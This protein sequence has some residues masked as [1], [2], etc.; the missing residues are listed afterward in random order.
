MNPPFVLGLGEALWDSL[1]EGLR[2]GGA[3]LNLAWHARQLGA[4]AAIL[5]S[6]GRDQPGRDLRRL[7]QAGG[8]RLAGLQTS[9]NPTGTVQVALTDDGQPSYVITR[10]VAW[11]DI[12]WTPAAADL[13]AEANALAFGTLAARGPVSRATIR[14]AVEHAHAHRTKVVLDLNLRP[15]RPPEDFIAWTLTQANLLKLNESETAQLAQHLQL[16]GDLPAIAR[17]VLAKYP[18]LQVLVVT[19]GARGCLIQTSE[20][21]VTAAPAAPVTV[22]DAV[23]AGDASTAAVVVG[24]LYGRP[25][26]DIARHANQV[27]GYVAGQAGA[28]PRLPAEI[29]VP[30]P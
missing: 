11:D 21:T 13:V 16:T 12:Q 3:P 9:E 5:S 14:A 19:L 20:E 29:M 26:A 17:G 30:T 2:P 1:P 18:R 10:D 28:M 24:W 6:V 27:G 4:E 8:L 23:G 15:E 7:I 22:V 25:W